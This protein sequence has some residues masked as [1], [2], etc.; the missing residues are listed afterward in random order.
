MFTRKKWF[1]RGWIE[2]NE[3]FS[4]AFGRDNIVYRELG[5]KM[6]ITADVGVGQAS[7]FVIS[8]GRWD[9]DPLNPV[10]D[11]AKQRIANNVKRALESQGLVVNLL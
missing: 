2:S 4:V 5:R 7:V 8:I 11:Q 1:H 9:D 6:A 10:S 3:G